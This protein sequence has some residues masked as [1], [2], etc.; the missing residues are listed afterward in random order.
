MDEAASAVTSDRADPLNAAILA[1]VL[2]IVAREGF[3]GATIRRVAAEADCSAG[4]VQKRF[5]TRTQL[6][7]SAF[8][9]VV[10]TSLE[11]IAGT[12]STAA[13]S[14]VERQRRAALETLPLD[15]VRRRE[16]LVWTSY[17]L[18]A[19]VDEALSDLPRQVD[20][21]VHAVLANELAD[22]QAAGVLRSDADPHVLTDALL[23]LVDGIA[24][25][26]LYTPP[27][28]HEALLA[29]LDA[30]LEALLPGPHRGT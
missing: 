24:M 21:T 26:M 12:D 11:R 10:T 2:A 1:A 23:G 16:G 9:L 18:R 28:E 15:A 29:A 22:A 19:A 4:A 3:E 6:L 20:R 17:V 5:P 27:A 8:E 7:R 30:G 14:L 25:R 13:H